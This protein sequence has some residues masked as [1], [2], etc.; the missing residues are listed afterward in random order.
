M[1]SVPLD[2]DVRRA[3][4]SSARGR[5]SILRSRSREENCRAGD[6]TGQYRAMLYSIGGNFGTVSNEESATCRI[7]RTV[8]GS[9]PPLS[10]MIFMGLQGST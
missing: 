10:A 1:V 6:A 7:R 5:A 8:L 2:L 3:K 4:W 9:N